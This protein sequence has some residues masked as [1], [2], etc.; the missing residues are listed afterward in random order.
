MESIKPA[1]DTLFGRYQIVV[2]PFLTITVAP[3]AVLQLGPGASVLCAWKIIIEEGGQVRGS[4][5][6]LTVQCTILQKKF[7]EV[8][9]FPGTR[10][11]AAVNL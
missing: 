5:P 7:I 6:S 4:G 11:T 2:W 9:P 1:L 3:G 10:R 8:L